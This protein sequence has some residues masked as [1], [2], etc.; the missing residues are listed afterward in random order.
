MGITVKD[1]AFNQDVKALT[2]K[3]YIFDYFLLYQLTAREHQL[4]NAVTATGIGAG[5]LDT[6]DLKQFPINI[7]SE[8]EQRK[9]ADC[10]TSLD[11]L[12]TTQSQKIEALKAQKKGLMQQI[13]P[14]AN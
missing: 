9:I 10:L 14:N 2:L 13:F 1:V 11:D 7:P 4:L 5:K 8:K 12:I 3:K 6:N